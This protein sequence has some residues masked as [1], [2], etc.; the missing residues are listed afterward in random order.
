MTPCFQRL[1][2]HSDSA[3]LFE[4]IR[5]QQWSVFLDSGRPAISQG[6]YDILAASPYL[7]LVTRGEETE[8]CDRSG[9]Q[10]SFEDPL[11][12]LRGYL[13]SPLLPSHPEIPFIGGAIGYFSYDLARRWL[14]L[15]ALM[16]QRETLPQM[17]IA[18][19]DWALVVD[20]ESRASWLVSLVGEDWGT[21][22]V[23][24]EL[25]QGFSHPVSRAERSFRLSSEIRSN[26]SRAAYADRFARIQ[27][28]IR[29]GD[30]YQVN[31]AQRFS[32]MIEGDAW[33]LYR[34]LRQV[35]PSPF[36][37]F[38]D[39]PFATILSTSPE[40]FLH[41]HRGRV[42]TRP[43][44]G[45]RPRNEDPHNDSQLRRSLATSEKDRA[46]N[47][48]IVDLLRNDLGRVCKT[49]SVKV[50]ALFDI[51]SFA[52]VHHMVSTVS[53]ELD[54]GR[55][56][57]D[58]LRA[59]FPGGS[60]TGAPKLRAMEIIDELEQAQ[61]GLYCGSIAY[62]GMDGS[63]DSNIA[64]RSLVIRDRCLDF[65]AG[66]GIVADSGEEA[67]YQESLDKAS[68]IFTALGAEPP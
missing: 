32:G 44:K 17:A 23:R 63:M 66:G 29:E 34:H 59:C 40:R 42:E 64:I 54:P 18:F 47:L 25:V 14:R 9:R 53:G 38:M 11:A 43:I 1:P 49:G 61:R 15:P 10:L 12:L 50:P 62:I 13:S 19:Y 2:Y 16:E 28:Y 41:L 27:H 6:R 51:E 5:H 20:H 39:Y 35:N 22:R 57:L 67:E 4:T 65:W 8:I 48:M 7:T 52:Q 31:F 36:S 45:T 58:L 37:A 26:L 55:D 24:S 56:A 68:A 30:C 60:I 46:E 3:D 21:E 33:S